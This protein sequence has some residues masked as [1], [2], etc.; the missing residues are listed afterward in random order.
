M[1]NLIMKHL[2]FINK[3]GAGGNE[4]LQRSKFFLK[5]LNY[6]S[7]ATLLVIFLGI[8]N[9]VYSN[10]LKLNPDL[11]DRSEVSAANN[12]FEPNTYNYQRSQLKYDSEL[13]VYF[14]QEQ[15][16]G[17]NA[18]LNS[19]SAVSEQICWAAG[20]G[21][22]V[23]KTT[24]RGTSWTNATGTGINGDVY[25]IFALDENTAFC[26]T[27]PLPGSSS[28]FIYKTSNSGTTW[29]QVHATAETGF[30]NAIEM[31]SSTEG[32]AVGDPLNSV[33]TILKTTNGGNNWTQIPTAPS[34]IGDEAGW[35]NSFTIVGTDMWF[36]TS[37]T[38]I[39]HSTNL[40]LTWTSGATTGTVS[41]FAVHYNDQTNGLAGG[42]SMVAST[43]GGTSYSL[44][45]SPAAGTINAISGEGTDWWAT[46]TGSSVYR[47]TNGGLNWMSV[48]TMASA[49]FRDIDVVTSAVCLS[50]WAVGDGGAVAK[51][52][53]IEVGAGSLSGEVPT[54]YSLKQNFPNPFNPS[55]NIAFSIP[56][57]G[58]VTLKVFDLNG[59]EVSLLINEVKSAGNYIV[60]FNASN[61]PSGL[62]FYK[63]T[64]GEYVETRKMILIK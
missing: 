17:T 44:V 61:L 33:W 22:T 47:S 48:Y 60:G 15:I 50:G 53:G 29:I 18:A 40:G 42:T 64:S 10:C 41:T 23:R 13:C 3:A 11:N 63:V 2:V 45:T 31:I 54:S 6:I 25:N 27:T 30:I 49:V 62:Y 38:K 5:T 46:Q 7:K 26:T 16:P 9:Y 28:S 35:N 19:V 39:Y 32:Y 8:S 52:G 58:L 24:D 36:G 51:I 56:K 1:L 4:F 20:D 59:K 55:T 21:P 12:S 34:Q 37:A 57:S 14:G 43:N